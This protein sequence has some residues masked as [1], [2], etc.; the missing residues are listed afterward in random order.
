MQASFT[1]DPSDPHAGQTTA[2]S[3]LVNGGAKPYAYTWNFGDGVRGRGQTVT[4][5]YLKAG[6][7]LTTLTVT[8][9]ARQVVT[10]SLTLNI[11]AV[12][13]P[14]SS[15]KPPSLGG[16][17]LQCP[18]KNISIASLILGSVPVALALAVAFTTLVRN[19]QRKATRRLAR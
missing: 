5:A 7:Y 2:F 1:D 9:A 14:P 16:F 18:I 19:H 10:A 4:H 17:C 8:D 3:A 15:T 6:T 11:A 13:S 12:P